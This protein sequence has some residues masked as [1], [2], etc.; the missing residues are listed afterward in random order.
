MQQQMIGC[1]TAIFGDP[2]DFRE[3]VPGVRINFV[4]TSRCGFKAR[5]TWVNMRRVRLTRCTE[6]APRVA[7]IALPPGQ[8]FISF[9]V[10]HDPPPV[11]SGIEMRPGEIMLHGCRD[12]TYQRTS[13][14][15][16]WGMISLSPKDLADFSQL[17]THA[18]L[19][20]PAT[21]KIVSP[22]SKSVKDLLRLHAR[23][24]RLAETKPEMIAHCEVARAIE[25]E[26]LCTLVNCLASDEACRNDGSSRGRAKAMARFE[27]A[28]A[29][30]D[31][32]RRSIPELATAAGVAERTLRRCC[33]TFLGM[34]PSQ[35][36]R[37]RQ[38]NLVRSALR[39][40]DPEATSVRAIARQHGIT[41]FG[42][43]AL[44]YRSFFGEAPSRTLRKF[45]P[46]PNLH[47]A[48]GVHSDNITAQMPQSDLP[49]SGGEPKE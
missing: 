32:A 39:R 24:C 14:A 26:M 23:A 25:E 18:R 17:L 10:H 41:E 15:G 46:R 42:R 40:A 27:K 1:G 36:A 49:H 44:A 2:E 9:P 37:L 8:V 34:S 20:P 13:G 28:L 21:S 48:R 11:W 29:S 33:D 30:P 6:T 7:F 45:H 38:L 19:S 47:S 31:S 22:S 5:L 12:R 16:R 3:N 4:L 35:Y 43:F